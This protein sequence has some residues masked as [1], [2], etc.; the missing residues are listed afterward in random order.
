M[1]TGSQ[2]LSLYFGG[3]AYKLYDNRISLNYKMPAVDQPVSS[4]VLG[5]HMRNG[6][7]D[8]KLYDWERYLDFA[9]QHMRG[10]GGG[11]MENPVT[12]EWIEGRLFGTHP[13]LILTPELEH[14]LWQQLDDGDSLAAMG[15]ELI[16]RN[17]DSIL[18]LDPLVREMTGR[19]LLGVWVTYMVGRPY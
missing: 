19:R 3:D 11:G 15:L 13:R 6:A 9:D 14:L 8:V 17:A 1:D 4:G 2:F 18:N 16:R 7:H 10:S 5:Y 12:R